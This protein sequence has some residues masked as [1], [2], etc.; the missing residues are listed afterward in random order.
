MI[1]VFTPVYN[2]AWELSKLKESL[3]NQIDNNFEWVIVDDGST[4]KVENLVRKWQEEVE[5]YDIVFKKQSNQGKHIAYNLGVKLAR[6]DWFICVDSDDF[7]TSDAI[8]IMN[9][10]ISNYKKNYIGI[11]YPQKNSSFSKESAWE[12]LDGKLVDIIDLKEKFSI[13]ESSILI[14][15]EYLLIYHFPKF[16]EEKFLSEGWLYQKLIREGK[17]LAH[18]HPFYISEYLE[19]GMTSNIWKLW[20]KNPVGVITVLQEKYLIVKKFNFKLKWCCR[21]KCLININVLCLKI[22]RN[23]LAESPSKLLS[24][25]LLLPSIYFYRKRYN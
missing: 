9:S 1:T 13:P 7:L 16:N 10:D 8:A 22:R 25:I 3:D 12:G 15:K 19:D 14:K 20:E 21:I 5:N 4:D 17:F 2:R 6:G 24:T 23:F 18:N 11:V